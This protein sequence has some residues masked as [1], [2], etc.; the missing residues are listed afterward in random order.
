MNYWVDYKVYQSNEEVHS[1]TRM[2]WLSDKADAGD[3]LN[4]VPLDELTRHKLS[5]PATDIRIEVWGV[6][7]DIDNVII[8]PLT[9]EEVKGRRDE[10]GYLEGVLA[11][12]VM[13]IHEHERD[14]DSELSNRFVGNPHLSKVRWQIVGHF[15][16][17]ED[18]LLVRVAGYTDKLQ[19]DN[20]VAS[21]PVMGK[22]YSVVR[23]D[24]STGQYLYVEAV[25]FE[26]DKARTEANRLSEKHGSEFFFAVATTTNIIH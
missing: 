10:N 7:R 1:G 13:D 8:N 17:E 11:V 5:D 18:M 24:R 14:M 19:L 15:K 3:V 21:P 4:T 26:E 9:K 22:A 6:E 16:N 2:L 12:S 20:E 23:L 25:A